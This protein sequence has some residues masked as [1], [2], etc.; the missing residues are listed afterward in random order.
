MSLLIYKIDK[1]LIL[2][3]KTMKT[4]TSKLKFMAIGA[5]VFTTVIAIHSCKKSSGPSGPVVTTT[6]LAAGATVTAGTSTGITITGTNLTSA[7]VTTTATGITVTNVT[8]NAGGTSIT[9]TVAVNASVA[10]GTISL[11]ITTAQGVAYATFTVV[12]LPV[13]GG[14]ISSDSVAASALVSYFTFNGNVNDTIGNESGTAVGV[15]YVTGVRGQAYQGATGAYATV[16]ASSAFGA[17]TS[18]SVS[19]WYSLP[20]AAKPQPGGNNAQGIFFVSGDTTGSHGNEIIV[21]SDVPSVSQLAADSVAI[22]HGFDNVGGTPGT[23]QNFTMNSFD[24][25]TSTWVHLVMTY[26]GPSS[27]YTLYENGQPIAV[28]SA[29]GVSTST[30]ILNGPGPLGGTTGL[31]GN[32]N[33][34]ED[35]PTTLFIGTWPPGLYGVS[36]TLGSNGCFKGAL[37]ELRVFKRALTQAEVVGLFLNGQAGR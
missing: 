32:L 17:L 31:Q 5:L 35:A 15:T 2:N 21:E 7:T 16:P 4:I 12:G 9:G 3:Q 8:I 10:S 30:I 18:Y 14:Y 20:T 23:W 19:L 28:S 26:D 29:Y 24:T 1:L 25:A 34:S 36:P 6:T 11:T 37:D 22:H 33:F 13:L 27:A